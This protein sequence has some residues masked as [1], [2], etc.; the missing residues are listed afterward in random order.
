MKDVCLTISNITA[1]G[2]SLQAKTNTVHGKPTERIIA[3]EGLAML[4]QV[5]RN[6]LIRSP[7]AD[8]DLTD[9]PFKTHQIRKITNSSGDTT[10]ARLRNQRLRNDVFGS[11]LIRH[12]TIRNNFQSNQLARL[13]KESHV[14]ARTHYV[15]KKANPVYAWVFPM[16]AMNTMTCPT[17]LNLLV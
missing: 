15:P 2:D 12:N 13:Y 4:D 6:R 11:C 17:A 5:P 16:M 1:V 8:S 3:H 7:K 14:Q 9:Q 10:E